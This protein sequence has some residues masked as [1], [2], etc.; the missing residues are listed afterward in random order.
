[1]KVFMIGGTG[2]LGSAAARLFIEQGHTVSTL[3]LAPLPEGAPI[4]KEMDI[5]FGSYL[6]LSDGDVRALMTGCDCFVFAAGVDER[7]EFPPPV[8]DAYEKYNIAPLKK[9]LPAAKECGVKTA[10]VLGSYFSYFA[11]EFPAMELARRHPY[12]Q[13]RVEQERVAFSYADDD[14]AVAVLELP[15][16]FGIQ[17][18]R[19]PVWTILTEQIGGMKGT[20]YYPKG[21]TTMVTVRQ[22]AQAIVGAAQKTR[23]AVAW[24][25]GYY[26]LTWNEFLD[27]VHDAMG[28]PGKKIVNVPKWM[29]RVFGR[30]MRK[31]YAEKGLEPGIDP[32]GLADIMG[33]NAFID[34]KWCVELGVQEDDIKSAVF[35]S[36]RLSMEAASGNSRLLDMKGE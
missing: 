25:V 32:V 12:I 31:Q 21:G 4:P 11:K 16:I 36:I 26:N 2:L 6:D 34:K 3:A 14:M 24:P 35:D 19:K 18:G 17:P 9:L 27:I 13:S 30:G 7:V 23:G 20:T 8:Y 22:V 10:V 5:T 15:Y 33:M 29:F 1:M 28:D